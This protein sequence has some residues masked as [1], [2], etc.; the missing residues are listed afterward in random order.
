[1]RKTLLLASVITAIA[2]TAGAQVSD[3]DQHW[4]ARAEGHRGGIAKATQIDAAIGAYQKAVTQET[5]NLEA[6][7]KLLRAIRFRGA[8]VA[9]TSEEKKHDYAVGKKEGDAAIAVV[10]RAL[11]AK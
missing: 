3:G 9:L 7:W 1:M 4:N 5:N 6:R 8:Y 11:A 10:N 2:M